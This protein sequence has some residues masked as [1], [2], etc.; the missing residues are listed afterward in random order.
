[1]EN[2]CLFQELEN[3]VRGNVPE[4]S[5]HRICGI[6]FMPDILNLTAIQQMFDSFLHTTIGT[7][8]NSITSEEVTVRKV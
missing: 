2:A 7:P 4:Q 6:V 3:S 5:L 8:W 1:M